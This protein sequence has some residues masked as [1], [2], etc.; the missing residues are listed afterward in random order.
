[1]Y[2]ESQSNAKKSFELDD[3]ISDLRMLDEL[4]ITI[5]RKLK[6]W[7]GLNMSDSFV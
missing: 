4:F 5:L 7:V 2:V 1:M 6:A 3:D